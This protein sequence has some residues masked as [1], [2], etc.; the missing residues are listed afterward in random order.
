MEFGFD[1]LQTV[2]GNYASLAYHDFI[3]FQVSRPVLER[4]F[5]KTYGIDINDVFGDL[6]LAIGTFR[7]S[8]KNMIP[9]ATKYAWIIKKKQINNE[10]TSATARNFKYKMSRAN[11]YEEF[12]KQHKKP[13]V[14]SW[15]FTVLMRF[16]PKIGP[17]KGL[18]FVE[19]A[20]ASE[21]LFIQSFDTVMIYYNSYLR[22]IGNGKAHFANKDLD[23]GKLSTQGEYDLCDENYSKL[24]LKLEDED[25]H[26]L[27][28]ALKHNI[29][30]FYS[31]QSTSVSQ[32]DAVEWKKLTEALA[33][34]HSAPTK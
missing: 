21:K 23:T 32:N 17:L 30:A 16:F 7:W 29:I 28:P 15:A 11:Y 26:H 13:P 31:H 1:V 3:G 8:V 10:K 33:E 14:T 34:L 2:K 20:E 4:A 6:S 27:S 18:R 22:K 19:P 25:F 24:L 5:L 9:E 12:G